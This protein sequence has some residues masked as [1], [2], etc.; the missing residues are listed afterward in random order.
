MRVDVLRRHPQAPAAEA[1]AL[2]GGIDGPDHQVAG[3]AGQRLCTLTGELEQ[4]FVRVQAFNGEGIVQ[5]QRQAQ[6]VI[7]GSEVGGGA[8]DP[9]RDT[10]AGLDELQCGHGL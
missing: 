2:E 1:Q 4:E 7:A 8:G 9:D 10:L 6:A 3:V 5:C